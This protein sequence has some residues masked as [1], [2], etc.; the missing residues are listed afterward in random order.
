MTQTTTTTKRNTVFE[1][2]VFEKH[3]V[4]QLTKNAIGSADFLKNV[5]ETV[6][7]STLNLLQSLGNSTRMYDHFNNLFGRG[8]N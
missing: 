6:L 8:N 3:G 4:M 1:I 2:L 7:L 5:F